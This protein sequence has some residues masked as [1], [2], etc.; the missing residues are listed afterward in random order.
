LAMHPRELGPREAALMIGGGLAL[1]ASMYWLVTGNDAFESR[2]LVAWAVAI[3]GLLSMTTGMV[4]GAVRL[5]ASERPRWWFWL[6]AVGI[7]TCEILIG[8]GDAT[9]WSHRYL[10]SDPRAQPG[11]VIAGMFFFG[12]LGAAFIVAGT[13]MAFVAA[14]GRWRP[15]R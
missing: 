15:K 4:R 13:V 6:A 12:F 3:L 9:A 10:P 11:A 8:V 5:P 14:S 1:V 7:G 2:L